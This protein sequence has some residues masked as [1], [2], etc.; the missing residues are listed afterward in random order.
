MVPNLVVERD[1]LK[2]R[3]N[4]LLAECYS[5]N[6]QPNLCGSCCQTLAH[7]FYQHRLFIVIDKKLEYNFLFISLS[8][9]HCCI[10]VLSHF[11]YCN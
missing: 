3:S 8:R 7:T 11:V 2:Q 4:T 5:A 10:S 9:F 6:V 1:G